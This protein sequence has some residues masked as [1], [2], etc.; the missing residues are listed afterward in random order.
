MT[1]TCLRILLYTIG[2]FSW[3]G[4]SVTAQVP[5][6]IRLIGVSEGLSHRDVKFATKDSR[7]FLWIINSVIDFYDGQSFTS[8]NKLDPNHFIPVSS[9]RTGCKLEDSLLLFTEAKDLYSLNMLNGIVHTKAYPKGMDTTFN[10]LVSIIDRQHQ[11]NLLL[12]TRTPE[13]STINVV[14]RKWNYLFNYEVSNKTPLHSKILRSYA[15]GPDGVLW[16]IDQANCQI[17]RI[18]S[19]GSKSYPFDVPLETA[20][21]NF[22]IV[23]LDGFGLVISR[24]DGLIMALREGAEDVT[25]VMQINFSHTTI[26]PSHVDKAGWIWSMSEERMVRFNVRTGAAELFDVRPFG[27]YSPVL[28]GSFEDEEGITWISSEVGLLQILPEPKPFYSFLAQS[29]ASRNLQFRDI[30]PAT[31]HSVYCRVFDERTSLIE[32][33]LY[34]NM[35]IDTVVRVKDIPKSGIFERQGDFLYYISSGT[36]N[37]LRFHLPDFTLEKIELPEFVTTQ[38][39]NLFLMDETGMIYYQDINN[40]LSG[41]NPS[42][43]DVRVI[44]LE[45]NSQK[46]NSPW[47][48]LQWSGKNKILIGTETTGMMLYDRRTGKRIKE[49]DTESTPPLSGNF[50][51]VTLQESDS[52]VWVGT[53]G[54]GI[55]RLNINTG[56]VKIY[57]TLDGLANNLVA[58]MVKDNGGNIWIGT[59]GG[60]SMYSKADDRFYNYYTADGISDDEFNY[61]SVY[62]D[63]HGLLYMGT[64]NGITIFDPQKITGSTPLPPVQLTRIQKYNRKKDKLIMKDKA[65]DE[66]QIIEVSPYDS[67]IELEFAVPSYKTNASHVFFSRL[68]EVDADWQNLGHNASIRY[69]KLPPGRYHLELMASDATGNKTIH[70]TMILLH[71]QQVYYKSFWFLSLLFLT[72]LAAVYALYRYRVNMLQKEHETRTR[73]ASDLHDEVGGSLTGLF[74]QLQMME[75]K[76]AGEARSHLNKVSTIIDESITKMRDLVWSID[77]RSD[78]WGKIIERMEDYTSD[79]LFPLD[80][81]FT[82]RHQHFDPHQHIDA[83]FKHNLYLIYKEA[84]H[85]IAKHSKATQVS[86]VLER[87]DGHLHMSINDD[88][89]AGER[90]SISTGQGLQ[91]MMMRAERLKGTIKTGYAASGGFSVELE[92]PL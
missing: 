41:F 47:R 8:Y 38:Y 52:I 62:K 73:I 61:L 70:T 12:F 36:K 13:G 1:A 75:F 43:H 5:P 39:Y 37:L 45:G 34:E 27:K 53:L 65:L 35:K 72:L 80:I 90:K 83:R 68:K 7:G 71:V 64:L 19:D 46:L 57:T 91:N 81:G 6:D 48:T 59:Y 82:F 2:I 10:D 15:N 20:E 16:L 79:I 77:A 42:T 60:L 55:N 17:L 88:G 51:N 14:D 9:I 29:N 11:P 66:I 87:K 32:I 89:Q 76:A 86:I 24:N 44:E 69:Q 85:N 26:H 49:F 84:I 33:Q 78:S 28:R 30:L 22:R 23:Y 58:N 50:I 40:H 63:P 67:Y 56:D 25:P 3:T 31:E 92:I 18:T 54:S 21:T 74:L 4:Y